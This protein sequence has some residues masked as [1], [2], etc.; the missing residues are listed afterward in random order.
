MP[1]TKKGFLH[2]EAFFCLL[3]NLILI[4]LQKLSNIGGFARKFYVIVD[5]L[6]LK[7]DTKS[8]MFVAK[9]IHSAET[10]HTVYEQKLVAK[11]VS[12]LCFDQIL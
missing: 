9:E 2:Q 5:A 7:L 12:K 8:D 4:S 1:H 6:Q 11:T 10:H 3:N